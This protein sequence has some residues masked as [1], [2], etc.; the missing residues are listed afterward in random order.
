[1]IHLHL[2]SSNVMGPFGPSP[3]FLTMCTIP[4]LSFHVTFLSSIIML[5]VKVK[6]VT[7]SSSTFHPIITHV[8]NPPSP[9]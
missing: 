4:N 3:P 6:R 8:T 2:G 5:H 7:H 1:M 9:P